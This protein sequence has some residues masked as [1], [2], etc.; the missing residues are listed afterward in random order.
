[1]FL[2]SQRDQ[3]IV[4]GLGRPKKLDGRDRIGKNR[5]VVGAHSDGPSAGVFDVCRDVFY[6]PGGFF[7][8][9]G[10][11]INDLGFLALNQIVDGGG[12]E[13]RCATAEKSCCQ[14]W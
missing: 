3:K 8:G 11:G 5:R 10:G 13:S 4:D 14:R 9:L 12:G 2:R 6:F 7:S 1:D